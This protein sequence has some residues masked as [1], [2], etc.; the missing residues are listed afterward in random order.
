MKKLLA[1]LLGLGIVACAISE[2]NQLLAAPKKPPASAPKFTITDATCLEGNTTCR[3]TITKTGVAR[4]ASVLRVRTA[5]GTALAGS[6]FT[7]FDQDVSFSKNTTSVDI[8]VNLLGDTAD[9]ADEYFR[10]NIT[11]QSNANVIDTQSIVTITDDDDA[12]IPDPPEEEPDAP[13]EPE[14][15]FCEDGSEIPVEEECP[16]EEPELDPLI[17]NAPIASNFDYNLSLVPSWGTG[18]IATTA[19][20]DVVGAF[21][22]ICG[23]GKLGYIDPIVNP[24]SV[25]AHLHQFYG[26]DGITADSTYASLRASGTS[27]C[28]S[29]SAGNY[30]ANR[31]G[32]WMP[33]MLDGKGSVVKPDFVSIY[34]KMLPTSHPR[35]AGLPDGIGTCIKLPNGLKFIFGYDMVTGKTPT[36]KLYYDCQGT[37]S[38][39]G[40]YTNFAAMV[41]KCPAGAQLGAIIEAP[42]CWDGKNLDTPNHRDHVAYTSDDSRGDGVKRCPATHP[43]LIPTF[44]LGAW[45]TMTAGDDL[46]LFSLSSDAMHPELPKG[47]TFH[48]D[49]FM[50]W[51]P[52]VHD[53]W[54]QNCISLM[55]NCSGGDL[56]NGKQLKGAQQPYYNGFLNWKN[57]NA[58]VAVPAAP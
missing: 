34:Y 26:N 33:A 51:D 5:N 12:T 8:Y 45:Y 35:C 20:P 31:S 27:T 40:K 2:P 58:R 38:L 30:S 55:L 44:T 11:G 25:S 7:S 18:R 15:K 57:P 24:G 47:T 17:G 37:G 43:Y 9:E 48:A 13:P 54:W 49:F 56:G 52:A 46:S 1:G 16:V 3:V 21:R 50:A 23:A 19:A 4:S 41:G 42:S 28:N 6:D 32:Y 39:P 36:G 10:V 53:M 22:F 14:T 29:D